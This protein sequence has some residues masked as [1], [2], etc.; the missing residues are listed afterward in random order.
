MYDRLL[1]LL[2]ENQFKRGT[3]RRRAIQAVRASKTMKRDRAIFKK[4]PSER[5]PEEQAS[6]KRA[7]KLRRYLNQG[8][9]DSTI[10]P[11]PDVPRSVADKREGQR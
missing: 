5:T 2:S 7:V 9:T 6:R 11:T 1:N 10:R 3:G 4:R 8:T